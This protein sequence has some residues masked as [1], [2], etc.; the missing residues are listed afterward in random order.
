MSKFSSNVRMPMNNSNKNNECFESLYRMLVTFSNIH[1][2]EQQQQ[3]QSMLL[4]V[5][6]EWDIVKPSKNNVCTSEQQQVCAYVCVE[7]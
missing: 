1:T 3:R 2:S 7:L 6:V 5:Y 4:T